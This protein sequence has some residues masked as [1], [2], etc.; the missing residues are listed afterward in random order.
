MNGAL[1]VIVNN[2]RGNAVLFLADPCTKDIIKELHRYAETGEHSPLEILV[3][4][5]L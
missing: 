3:R 2:G 4:A 1:A 5:L